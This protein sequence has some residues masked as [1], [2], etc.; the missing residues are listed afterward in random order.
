MQTMAD[1]LLD[2]EAA[3][4]VALTAGKITRALR[5]AERGYPQ[6]QSGQ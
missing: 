6:A 1:R 2:L 3:H 5:R 4:A